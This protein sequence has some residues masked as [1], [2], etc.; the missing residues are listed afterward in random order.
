[1]NTRLLWKLLLINIL[2]ILCVTIE[3]LI[4]ILARN[5]A[6][7]SAYH[8]VPIIAVG[9]ILRECSDF[10]RGVLL[11][12]R[13]TGFVG[14]STLIAIV[15][16]TI[17]Y[18]ALIPYFKVGGAAWATLFTFG[19][20]ALCMFVASQRVQKVPY[21]YKRL[22]IMI[23]LAL[24]LIGGLN[25]FRI[26][27][28]YA[29]LILKGIL[30]LSFYPLLYRLGFFTAEEREKIGRWFGKITGFMRPGNGEK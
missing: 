8:I 21:E 1:M 22:A 14:L 13:R 7:Y 16:C 6:F 23:G 24:I 18:V 27:D 19:A 10:F 25:S 3:D 15:V 29:D 9:Y 17:F 12:K 5:P 30:C 28:L 26:P 4:R 11:I 20:M 2:V